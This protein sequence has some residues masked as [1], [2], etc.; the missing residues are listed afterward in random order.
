VILTSSTS[1]ISV[2]IC[3]ILSSLNNV[4]CKNT[5]KPTVTDPLQRVMARFNLYQDEVS[6]LMQQLEEKG[7][8]V[9]WLKSVF[10]PRRTLLVIDMQNDF[11]N[12]SLPVAG[13]EDIIDMVEALT[14]MDIWYQVLWSQDW[15]P[16]D[17]IS[18]FSALGLRQL[19]PTWLSTSNTN[20]DDIKM[21]D[22]V[23]FKRYPPYKQRLWPDHCVQ[24]AEG[25]KFHPSL[26]K[27]KKSQVIQKGT[28]P[29]LDSYSAFFDN[30]DIK[31]SGDTGLKRLVKDS[32][33][34]VVVG[35]A[36]DYCVAFTSIDS[37][38]LGFPTFV[39]TD[40]TRPVDKKTGEVMMEKVRD[41]GGIVTTLGDYVDELEEW[42]KAK[43]IARFLIQ[44]SAV[45]ISQFHFLTLALSAVIY[46]IVM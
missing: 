10:S 2:A 24:G 43:E 29:I 40:H 15:H 34:I 44:N 23:V 19:D 38:D 16:S 20:V 35:L 32:T 36:Q 5:T 4:S 1:V 31:G 6:E 22:E 37:L 26:T 18:F 14:K 21:F 33:E 9:Q 8:K 3:V 39:L 45:A 27:P 41:A 12:G 25:A 28:N 42:S 11:I 46:S 17:H 7:Q 30:T 13:A